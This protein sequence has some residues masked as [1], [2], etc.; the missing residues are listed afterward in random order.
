MSDRVPSHRWINHKQPDSKFAWHS[1]K[2]GHCGNDV[3]GIVHS[4]FPDESGPIKWILC[5]KCENGSV[6]TKDGTMHPFQLFGTSIVGLP[7]DI[8]AAY[9]EA[10]KC[11]SINAH[12]ACEQMCR[13][14]L[15][16][17]AVEKGAEEGEKFE[18]YVDYLAKAGYVTPPMKGWVDLIRKNGNKSTHK[19]HAPDPVRAESTLVFTAELLKLVYEMEHLSKKYAPTSNPP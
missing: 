1:F 11:F 7:A 5:P 8:D 14:I 10:R 18:I 12:T 13:K 17:V 6:L 4:T 2:C 16:H 15:M 19:L 9:A 3:T